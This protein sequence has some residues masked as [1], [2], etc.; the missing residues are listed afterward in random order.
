MA[1]TTADVSATTDD[2]L[3]DEVLAELAKMRDYLQHLLD[4]K[5]AE[6]DAHEGGD[7]A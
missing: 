4:L 5:M 2:I 7:D 1:G 6:F 3:N